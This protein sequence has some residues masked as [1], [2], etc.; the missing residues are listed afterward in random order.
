MLSVD[1]IR[2]SMRSVRMADRVPPFFLPRP[3]QVKYS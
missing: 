1:S 2:S 3:E